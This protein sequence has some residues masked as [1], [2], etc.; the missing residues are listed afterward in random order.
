MTPRQI[1]FALVGLSVISGS[2]GFNLLV[3]QPDGRQVRQ[4]RAYRGLDSSPGTASSTL[5]E[6]GTAS[7]AAGKPRQASQATDAA[8]TSTTVAGSDPALTRS[9]QKALAARGYHA[10]ASDGAID[11]VTRAAILE[12]EDEYGLP[13]TAS[14]SRNVLD[15]L[16][17]LREPVKVPVSTT[18]K[19]GPEVEGLIRTV[20]LSLRRHGYD[21]G[22]AD[23]QIGE[24][25]GA[26]I[27]A[28]ERDNKLAIRGRISASLLT[29]LA[30]LAPVGRVAARD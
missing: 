30:D 21:P 12:F 8:A 11:V 4:D 5:K 27:R 2:V 16:Q 24:G 14:P 25:T 13:L 26:A 3:M 29:R 6:K 28:F 7:G 15:A 10:G 9:I 17:R 20:Q 1:R 18:V 23:G 22:T 19:A